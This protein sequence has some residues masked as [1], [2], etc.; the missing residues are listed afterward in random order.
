MPKEFPK[1]VYKAPDGQ[2]TKNGLAQPYCMVCLTIDFDGTGNEVGKGLKPFG[3]HSIGRYSARRGV[4]RHLELL[5]RLGIPATFFIPGYDAECS[6]DVVKEIAVSGHEI[7]AHGYLHEGVLL[8]PYEEARRLKHTHQILGELT[9]TPPKGWRSPSGQK[10][11]TTLAALKELGY[12]YDSSDKDADSP[13]LLKMGRNDTLVEI[14]NNTYSLDDFP[15]F[16]F[17]MTPVSE[18]VEQWEAEFSARYAQGGFF[19]LT[20]HPRAGWGAGT[21]SRTAGL[22]RVLRFIQQHQGVEFM[23]LIDV[24]DHVNENKG[25]YDEVQV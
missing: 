12:D 6:P 7:G 1:L 9:G 4:P 16:N 23:R 21:P 10:T 5:E 2:Q 24:S 25:A 22:E 14:P 17:S 19:M 15:F 20:I 13:Y 11:S 8:E 3:K 18:V